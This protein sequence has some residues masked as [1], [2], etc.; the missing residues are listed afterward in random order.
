MY[1][2]LIVDDEKTVRRALSQHISWD[3][4]GCTVNGIAKDGFEAIESIQNS[5]PDIVI[6]DI[7]MP[8]QNGIDVAQFVYENCPW[9]KVIILS[10]YA[11]FEYAQTAISF[12]VASYCLKPIDKDKLLKT[13]KILVDKMSTDKSR[14]Q[15]DL[16]GI[17]RRISPLVKKALG[18]IRNNYKE[19][20]SLE[21]IADVIPTNSSYLSRIF[22]KE[23]GESIT[24]YINRMRIEKAK[25]LLTYTDMLAY[26]VAESVGFKDPTYFSLVFK[27]VVGRSPKDFKGPD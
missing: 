19:N 1:S 18:Y 4:I 22:K 7:K 11:E 16:C 15:E 25:E 8:R 27:K 12:N 26:Q 20:L 17:N 3:N 2:I 9:I 23:T 13:V 6:T 21:V 5:P 14:R 10:G 24:E